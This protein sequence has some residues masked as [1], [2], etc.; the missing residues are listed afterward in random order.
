MATRE[1]TAEADAAPAC[2]YEPSIEEPDKEWHEEMYGD[3][4]LAHPYIFGFGFGARRQKEGVTFCVKKKFTF[5]F[6]FA[7]ASRP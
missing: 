1:A 2:G 3:I 6:R 7:R 5:T 4:L